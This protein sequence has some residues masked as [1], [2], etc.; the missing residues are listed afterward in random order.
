MELSET[1][2]ALSVFTVFDVRLFLLLT[3]LILAR[4]FPFFVVNYTLN[5]HLDDAVTEKTTINTD[6][7]LR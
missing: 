3:S 1:G 7:F 4:L 2:V 6:N 5:I